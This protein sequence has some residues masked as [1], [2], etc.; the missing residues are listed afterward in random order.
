MELAGVAFVPGMLA[1]GESIAASIAHAACEYSETPAGNKKSHPGIY[2]CP[3]SAETQTRSHCG[4]YSNPS[5]TRVESSRVLPSVAENQSYYAE[6][7]ASDDVQSPGPVPPLMLPTKACQKSEVARPASRESE[8]PGR[9]PSIA[10]LLMPN[11]ERL[12][13]PKSVCPFSMYTGETQRPEKITSLDLAAVKACP[14]WPCVASTESKYLLSFKDFKDASSASNSTSSTCSDLDL[15]TSTISFVSSTSDQ[16]SPREVCNDANALELGSPRQFESQV[17]QTVFL[18]RLPVGASPVDQ[19]ESPA[20]QSSADAPV[21]KA[22][23]FCKDAFADLED[24]D[25]EMAELTKD[26]EAIRASMSSARRL[27]A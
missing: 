13:P 2:S 15:S 1:L 26:L 22:R 7:T 3:K 6:S 10:Y 17:D 9:S 12:C 8:S 14:E 5:A 24:L 23:Q 21:S 20:C 27:L 4:I 19:R 16:Q 25:G 18:T 11:Q